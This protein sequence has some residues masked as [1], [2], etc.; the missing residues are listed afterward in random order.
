MSR[1]AGQHEDVAAICRGVQE[2]RLIARVALGEPGEYVDV[3]CAVCPHRGVVGSRCGYVVHVPVSF[4]H[5]N[6]RC[7]FLPRPETTTEIVRAH[8]LTTAK[9]APRVPRVSR[10]KQRVSA[11]ARGVLA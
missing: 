9:H 5:V 4:G 11:L 8:G 10:A 3:K 7:G 1:P 2:M 6:L